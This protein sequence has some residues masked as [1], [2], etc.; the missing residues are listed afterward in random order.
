MQLPKEK[1]TGRDKV[2]VWNEQ[3]HTTTHKIAKRAVRPAAR[4]SVEPSR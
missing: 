1:W 3:I 4:L 2:G